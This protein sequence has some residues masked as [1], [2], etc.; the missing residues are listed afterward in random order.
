SLG[1]ALQLGNCRRNIFQRNRAKSNEPLRIVAAI[2]SRP[3]IKRT[4]A[5]GAQ[6]GV[7]QPKQQH[8]H[9]GVKR[10]GSDSVSVLFLQAFRRVPQALGRDVEAGFGVWGEFLGALAGPKKAGDGEGSNVPAE[11][12]FS[13]SATTPPLGGGSTIRNFPVDPSPPHLGRL[14]K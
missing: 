10:F 8:P 12:N 2:V 7:I 4:E 6:G 1:D 14:H 3:V 9:R 11:K 13:F 5:G